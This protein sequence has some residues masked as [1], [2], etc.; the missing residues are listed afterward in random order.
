LVALLLVAKSVV[1]I[2]LLFFLA[3][4]LSVYLDSVRDLFVAK[5][6]MSE[7]WGFVAAVVLSLLI[8]WGIWALLVPPVVA[9]TRLLISRIPEMAANWK[10]QLSLLVVRYPFMEP[11]IGPESQT[12]LIGAALSEA[13]KF[14]GSLLPKVFDL[15]HVLIHIVSVLVEGMFLTLPPET[16]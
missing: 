4:L 14:A 13:E 3:V 16:Y 11:Y 1:S 5:L 10:M 12:E 9:Q 6:K 2:L 15:V 8:L 7:K